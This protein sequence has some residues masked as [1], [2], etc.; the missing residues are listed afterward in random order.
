MQ[1]YPHVLLDALQLIAG[2]KNDCQLAKRLHTSMGSI[3]RIR[4]GTQP[5]SPALTLAIYDNLGMS[6]ETIRDMVKE[7]TERQTLRVKMETASRPTGH[8]S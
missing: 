2:A 3:S 7:N 8:G 5:V 4:R 1:R 6:I